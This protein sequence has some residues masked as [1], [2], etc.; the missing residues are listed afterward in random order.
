M[1]LVP[2]KKPDQGLRIDARVYIRFA[3]SLEFRRTA[4]SDNRDPP[5]HGQDVQSRLD[6]A[7]RQHDVAAIEEACVRRSLTRQPFECV[8]LGLDL[9]A[10]HGRADHRNVGTFM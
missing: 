9:E 10:V 8:A 1:H 4:A 3:Y 2:P 6:M 7:V 5:P